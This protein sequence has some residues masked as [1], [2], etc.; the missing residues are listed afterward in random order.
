M[1]GSLSKERNMKP[2]G[3]REAVA[4][5][6]AELSESIAASAGEQIRFEVGEMQIEFQVEIE[7]SAEG[8]GGIRFWVVELGA[9]SSRT[10]TVTHTVTIPLKPVT[11][12]GQPLLTGSSNVPDPSAS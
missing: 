12:S 7:R 3:I 2:I 10:S 6:R 5:L 4:A 11:N 1:L 9:K 8:S